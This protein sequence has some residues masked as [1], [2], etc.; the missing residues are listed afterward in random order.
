MVRSACEGPVGSPFIS[1]TGV[2]LSRILRARRRPGANRAGD[3]SGPDGRIT[4]VTVSPCRPLIP[5]RRRC[6]PMMASHRPSESPPPPPPEPVAPAPAPGAKT[7]LAPSNF[8][9]GFDW[10]L[11]FGVLALAFL[12]ASFGVRNSDFWMHLAAGRL[13]AEGSYSFGKDPFSF[14]GEDRTWVNHAW[15]FDWLLYLLYKSAGGPGVVIAKAVA[16]AVTAGLLLLAR[17][18]GQSVFPG[19]ICVGLALIASAPRLLLQP[20]AASYLFLAALM[21]LLIRFP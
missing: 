11:A 9:V 19:V 6:P 7:T 4:S 21:F 20:T 17:K 13:L 2:G 10:V 16:L 15:L 14:V 3:L 12:L 1:G 8:I 18:P 5:R